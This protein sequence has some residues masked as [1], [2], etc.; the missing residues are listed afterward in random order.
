MTIASFSKCAMAISG[1]LLTSSCAVTTNPSG[2]AARNPAA[3]EGFSSEHRELA[4]AGKLCEGMNK[5][6]VYIAWGRPDSVSRG[7]ETGRE[8]EI[9]RYT[10][11]RTYYRPHVGLGYGYGRGYGHGGLHGG[12]FGGCDGF[13]GDPFYGHGFSHGPDYVPVT[14]GVV[15]FKG[16]VVRAWEL[17]E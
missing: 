9:W 8:V 7:S 14:S 13:S 12:G 6:A 16:G 10:T 2:R 15:R 5:D 4:L 17:V 3:V 11:L 1:A